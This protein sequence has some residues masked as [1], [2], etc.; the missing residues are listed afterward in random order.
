MQK[1]AKFFKKKTVLLVHSSYQRHVSPY[2]QWPPALCPHCHRVEHFFHWSNQVLRDQVDPRAVE[3]Q[4]DRQV[5]RLTIVGHSQQV[6]QTA[7]KHYSVWRVAAERL[8]NKGRHDALQT[9]GQCVRL[10]G[11]QSTKHGATQHTF[12][13]VKCL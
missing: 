4:F 5:V 10:L 13:H 11:K 2:V 1:C 12:S 3:Q 7:V 6:P 8:Q 9:L